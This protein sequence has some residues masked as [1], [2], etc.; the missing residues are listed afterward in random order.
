MVG[1]DMTAQLGSVLIGLNVAF[2]VSAVVLV[3]SAWFANRR[4]PTST[5]S[6]R[7]TATKT[8]IA[9]LPTRVPASTAAPSCVTSIPEAA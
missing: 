5:A 8:A 6:D 7:F 1:I 3:A 4:Q 2:I 9:S